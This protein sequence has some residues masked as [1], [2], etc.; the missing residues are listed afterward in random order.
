MFC[1]CCKDHMNR[2]LAYIT[3]IV[4]VVDKASTSASWNLTT[5]PVSFGKDILLRCS[6][7]DIKDGNV[8]LQRAEQR[9]WTGGQNYDLLCMNGECPNP[10]KYEMLTRNTSKDFDLLIHNFSES[11]LDYPYTCSCGFHDFT[12]NL[13]IEPNHVMS[14]PAIA[15]VKDKNHINNDYMEIEIMLDKVNPVPS[16]SALFKGQF[17]NKTKVAVMK[18]YTYHTDV[19]VI[20]DFP[21]DDV[22]CEGRLQ[23]LCTLVYRNITIFDEYLDICQENEA[24]MLTMIFIGIGCVPFVIILSICINLIKRRDAQLCVQCWTNGMTNHVERTTINQ[25]QLIAFSEIN[26]QENETSPILDV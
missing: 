23:I 9:Q 20:Y 17:I 22:G 19:K 6:I 3:M 26:Q 15:T 5:L 10:K 7:D 24:N 2:M 11:D 25:A 21:V 14:L 13:S 16:C 4:F 12:K 1:D 18:W 8:S